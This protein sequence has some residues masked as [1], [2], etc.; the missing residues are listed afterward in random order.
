MR[1]KKSKEK[2]GKPLVD[3]KS[4]NWVF[5][6]YPESAPKNWQEML[7]ETRLRMAIS[8]CHDKDVDENGTD[9]HAKKAH[10]HVILCW[11]GGSTTYS[12]VKRITDSLNAPMPQVCGSVR[13]SYRYLTHKDNADKYQY[14]ERDI[15]NL[16]GFNIL[17]YTELT[18]RE[19]DEIFIKLTEL[20]RYS[21][22]SEYDEF[23]NY[24]L[25]NGQYA[26]FSIARKN[27]IYFDK[28]ITSK[29]HRLAG[30]E[31]D[32]RKQD[33]REVIHGNRETE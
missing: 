31:N 5:I 19:I 8:P 1:P 2:Q 3:I 25:D 15:V 33:V 12:V 29:R 22:I 9:D 20:A 16:N 14:D 17:D 21:S 7:Q 6:V 10:Y 4:R 24:L 28:Y 27:T 13:G 32:R 11:D 23:C 18:S 30:E 26:E